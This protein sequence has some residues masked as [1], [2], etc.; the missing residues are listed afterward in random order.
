M[1]LSKKLTKEQ[2]ASI[3]E[4]LLPHY[5]AVKFSH[6]GNEIL[7]HKHQTSENTLS[8]IVFINGTVSYGWGIPDSKE[9]KSEYQPYLNS[10]KMQVY[11]NKTKKEIIKIYGKRRALKE[12]PELNDHREYWYPGFATFSTL[13]GVFNKLEGLTLVT[14]GGDALKGNEAAS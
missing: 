6:N 12:C 1:S 2:W 3:K 13:K 11:S 5:G 14:T 7:L 4:A 9:F 10:K 8:I